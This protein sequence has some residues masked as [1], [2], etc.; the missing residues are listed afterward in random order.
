MTGFGCVLMLGILQWLS[1][2]GFWFWTIAGLEH[3]E[4]IDAH[5]TE[6]FRQMWE[7]APFFAAIPFLALL[8]AVGGRL[9]DQSVLWVG[10]LLA[11]VPASLLPYAKAGGYLNNL[12][13]M[14]VLC[15]PALVLPI[16]DIARQRTTWSVLARWGTL[17][18]LSFFVS[19]KQSKVDDYLPTPHDRQA[20]RELNALV[21]ARTGG[22]V[23]PYLGF[24]P[25]RNGHG[26]PHWQSMIVWDSIWRGEPMSEVRAYENSGAH[27]AL[28]HSKDIG[29]FANYV[30][31]NSRLV[32]KLPESARIRMITGAAVVIDELWERVTPPRHR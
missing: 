29:E 20:A 25:A 14:V 6:G 10:A 24:L 19:Q 31:R 18:G 9:S 5:V 30:R 27:W 28:L 21:A 17:A 16:A 7:F 26:N 2:G 23:V 3:H 11:A 12:M 15:G 22:L 1:N 4:L 13:P 8:L 32:Q